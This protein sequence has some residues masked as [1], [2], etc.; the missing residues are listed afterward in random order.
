MFCVTTVL[1]TP[2]ASSS[3]SATCAG[4]GAIACWCISSLSFQNG[5][6]SRSKARRDAVVYGSL[7]VQSPF[8]ERKSGIP[9]PTE[10]PA[11]VR[12]VAFRADASACAIISISASESAAKKSRSS[13]SPSIS[14]GAS[15]PFPFVK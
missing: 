3:A 6:G 11:P 13:S 10:I 4:V 15:A 12:T 5:A 1:T 2:S 8:D 14:G 9:A 7:R